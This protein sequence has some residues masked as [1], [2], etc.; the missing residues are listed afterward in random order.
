[1]Q[2]TIRLFSGFARYLPPG[3]E[4]DAITLA[5]EDDVTVSGLIEQFHLPKDI[6]KVISVNEDIAR[7][8]DMLHDLD[9][10]K[11]FPV[12]KGG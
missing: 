3:N 1:M 11:I 2:I 12:S 6:P 5:V 7:E 9:T 10:V 8:D 4:G